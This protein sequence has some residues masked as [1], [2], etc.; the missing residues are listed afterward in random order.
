[1]IWIIIDSC[2]IAQYAKY[3]D[4]I[5][6]D[7]AC[8]LIRV[9]H[10]LYFAGT[11]HV[12]PCPVSDILY[13]SEQL[14]PEATVHNLQY[15]ISPISDLYLSHFY[16]T[17]QHL[18]SRRKVHTVNY[19]EHVKFTVND[20]KFNCIWFIKLTFRSLRSEERVKKKLK[21]VLQNNYCY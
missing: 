4:L 20:C 15:E 10:S 13:T 7:W 21:I 8:A 18:L 17:L 14:P 16:D 6:N 19:V 3:V 11:K 12:E 5:S 2:Y 9:I 1:M